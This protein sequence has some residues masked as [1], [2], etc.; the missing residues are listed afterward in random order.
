MIEWA[1]RL[2][3]CLICRSLGCAE[4]GPSDCPLI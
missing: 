3:I 4:G 2:A 1:S